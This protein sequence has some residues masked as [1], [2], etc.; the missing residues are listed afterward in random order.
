M[1]YLKMV[2]LKKVVKVAW[3]VITL[4]LLDY[5]TVTFIL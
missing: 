3:E 5:Y 2:L 4:A 1:T